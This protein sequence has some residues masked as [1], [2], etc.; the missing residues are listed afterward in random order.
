MNKPPKYGAGS[1]TSIP[2]GFQRK[3]C[4]EYAAQEVHNRFVIMTREQVK[5]ILNRVLTWPTADQEKVA[6]FADTRET[7]TVAC[8]DC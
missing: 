6:R 5:D 7:S 4:S 2:R 8:S 1:L 3:K